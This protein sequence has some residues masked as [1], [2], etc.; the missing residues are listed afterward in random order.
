M[1]YSRSFLLFKLNFD[2]QFKQRSIKSIICN[3]FKNTLFANFGD[4]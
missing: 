2:K 4:L 3:E 1:F